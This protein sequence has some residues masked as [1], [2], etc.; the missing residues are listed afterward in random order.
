MKKNINYSEADLEKYLHKSVVI[1]Y[2]DKEKGSDTQIL[3]GVLEEIQCS[4]SGDNLPVKLLIRNESGERL[5][6]SIY[7]IEDIREGE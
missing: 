3:R 4:D 5:K 6:I 1:T 2:S 7:D